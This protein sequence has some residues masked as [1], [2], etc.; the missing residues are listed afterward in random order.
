MEIM[1]AIKIHLEVLELQTG[2][3]LFFLR[4]GGGVWGANK[5]KFYVN[6][7]YTEKKNAASAHRNLLCSHTASATVCAECAH[8]HS[9]VSH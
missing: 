4:R 7:N 2:L 1:E 6:D 8:F 5:S 9:G 3:R